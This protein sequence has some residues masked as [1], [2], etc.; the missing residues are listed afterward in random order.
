VESHR[1]FFNA[2]V[3]NEEYFAAVVCPLVVHCTG[4]KH[5]FQFCNFFL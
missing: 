4:V 2:G 5:S 1:L 3:I